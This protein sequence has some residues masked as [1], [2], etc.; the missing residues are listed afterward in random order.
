MNIPETLMWPQHRSAITA[1]R[2]EVFIEEQAVPAAEEWDDLDSGAQHLGIW[3][4]GELVA[5]SRLLPSGKLTRMA[6]AAGDRGRGLGSALLQFALDRA[7]AKRYS[8]VFLHAQWA[9][10]GLYLRAGF[11]VDGPEFLEAGIRHLPMQL[12]LDSPA[13]RF[14]GPAAA[15]DALLQTL[16]HTDSRLVIASHSL[17]AWLFG[18]PAMVDL[19]SRVARRQRRARV[20][21]LV[22]EPRQESGHGLLQLAL[23]LPSKI[24]VRRMSAAEAPWRGFVAGDDAQLVYFSDETVPAGFSRLGARA[25]V[26]T[27]LERFAPLWDYASESEPNLLRF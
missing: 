19:I 1:L 18:S 2:T 8:R 6:V 9:A 11:E 25:E 22:A 21:V 3:R 20:R 26:R 4:D 15:A 23:R 16:R 27:E 24:E 13:L 10:R 17:P 12:A 5:Y 7:R 14:H